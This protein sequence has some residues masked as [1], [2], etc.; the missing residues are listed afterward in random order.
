MARRPTT[1]RTS[2]A[3]RRNIHKAQ[4]S[5]FRTREPRQLGRARTRDSVRTPRTTGA[6]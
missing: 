5:R 2:A 4:V 3:A 6:L 1:T